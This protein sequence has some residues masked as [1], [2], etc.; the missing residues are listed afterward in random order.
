[1]PAAL[2]LAEAGGPVDTSNGDISQNWPLM[3][4]INPRSGLIA[5][6]AATWPWPPMPLILK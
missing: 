2:S 6:I 5:T 1:M 3:L 4:S